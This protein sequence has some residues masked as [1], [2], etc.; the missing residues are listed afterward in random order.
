MAMDGDNIN[1]MM[2]ED[3]SDTTKDRYLTFNIDEDIYG[4]DIVNVRGI[5]KFTKITKIPHNPDF[6][7]GIFNL[8]GD[9]I[10]VLDVRKRF[11]KQ[12]K[13]P[14]EFTCIIVIE[15]NNYDLGLIVDRVNEVPT[16][17]EYDISA[18]PSAKLNHYNQYIRNI[19][20][21]NEQVVLLLDLAK[22]LM[23]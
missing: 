7:E 5:E 9:I 18:P 6:V 22:L 16:I 15:Y 12:P 2:E 23:E 19:G 1:I 13:E 20:K 21:V 10:G 3:A 14:D 11:M 4:I 17:E 8:R